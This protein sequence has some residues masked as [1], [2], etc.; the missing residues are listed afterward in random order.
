MRGDE[1]REF[2]GQ[3]PLRPREKGG[4]REGEGSRQRAHRVG[5]SEQYAAN[6]PV[7]ATKSRTAERASG[8]P[9]VLRRDR[10][11]LTACPKV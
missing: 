9:M 4:G 11:P 5:D 8:S 1:G 6:R 10:G 7:A 3:D 2:M